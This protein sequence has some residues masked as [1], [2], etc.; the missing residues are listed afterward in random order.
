MVFQFHQGAGTWAWLTSVKRCFQA[1]ADLRPAEAHL[2]P[3]GES[4]ASERAHQRLKS[5]APPDPKVG[6]ASPGNHPGWS[7]LPGCQQSWRQACSAGYPAADRHILNLFLVLLR[8]AAF[9]KPAACPFLPGSRRP[10]ARWRPSCR[11]CRDR[12]I[13][14]ADAFHRRVQVGECLAGDH[15]AYFAAKPLVRVSSWTI[16]TLPVSA[17]FPARLPGP[18]G[19]L[20]KSRTETR[21]AKCGSLQATATLPPGDHRQLRALHQ[22]GCFPIWQAEIVPRIGTATFAGIQ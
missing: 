20:R 4:V 18:R 16:N 13:W 10:T 5:Q 6:S 9:R 14:H 22:S 8:Q 1:V 12:D 21:P 2:A 19:Y 15:R 11:Y 7:G 17:R 3:Q